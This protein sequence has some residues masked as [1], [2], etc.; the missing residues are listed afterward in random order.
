MLKVEIK[1]FTRIWGCLNPDS[2]LPSLTHM[3]ELGGHCIPGYQEISCSCSLTASQ[4]LHKVVT[5]SLLL[6]AHGEA[7]TEH[8]YFC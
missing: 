6:H 3:A 4:L 2:L 8:Y 1:L 7:S 5:T